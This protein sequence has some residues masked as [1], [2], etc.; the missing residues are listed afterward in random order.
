MLPQMGTYCIY[1]R[2]QPG[3]LNYNAANEGVYQSFKNQPDCANVTGILTQHARQLV[4]AGVDHV[5]VVSHPVA[6]H[7]RVVRWCFLGER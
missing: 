2:R 7:H 5:V 4:A 1:Q 3:Q 6:Y